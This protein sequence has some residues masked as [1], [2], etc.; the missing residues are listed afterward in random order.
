MEKIKLDFPSKDVIE[1]LRT[2]PT[3][4]FSDA[5]TQHGILN[6]RIWG[7]LPLLPFD[8]PKKHI[9]G[10]A[11]T[12]RFLPT[13][14]T[15]AVYDSPY[16]HTQI[17]QAAPAG[18]VIVME[19]MGVVGLGERSASTA[20][21]AGIEATISDGAVRDVDE[22]K[23]MKC[24]VFVPGGGGAHGIKMASYVSVPMECV[25]YN[26]PIYCGI[27]GLPGAMVRPGD[28]IVG[29]NNGVVV[30]PKKYLN[31][32]LKTARDEIAKLEISMQKMID[33]GKSWEE[34]YPQVHS[35]KYIT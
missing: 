24:P 21:N 12:M 7:I 11:V 26:I 10:P 1:I 15:K 23:A 17:I 9:A 18:S 34:I 2:L 20:M 33:E 31:D 22:V 35:K 19:G 30:L 6:S 8:D 25:G 14:N 5:L 16:K 27:P 13:Y 32:L 28:I 29:D 3:T 4:Y